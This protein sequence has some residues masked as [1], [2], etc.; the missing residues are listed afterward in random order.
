MERM[1]EVYALAK[2]KVALQSRLNPYL[3]RHGIL[4]TMADLLTK[5]VNGQLSCH[6]WWL[7]QKGETD[8]TSAER[9]IT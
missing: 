4:L 3:T 6:R 1:S 7:K 9:A 5:W 8:S 2:Q